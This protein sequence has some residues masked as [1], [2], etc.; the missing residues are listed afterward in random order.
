MR[1]VIGVI[2]LCLGGL[3]LFGAVVAGMSVPATLERF[4]AEPEDLY[5]LAILLT[6]AALVGLAATNAGQILIRGAAAGKRPIWSA[7]F[8]FMTAAL[9]GA[10][11][12]AGFTDEQPSSY[13]LRYLLLP[14]AVLAAGA[15]LLLGRRALNR[16]PDHSTG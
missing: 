3:A 14:A 7:R 5:S 11:S 10:A 12:I 15:Y 4:S 6:L 2:N 1:R 16:S 13:E 8:S 9:L